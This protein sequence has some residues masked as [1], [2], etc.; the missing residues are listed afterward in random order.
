MVFYGD[1]PTATGC[2][3][4]YVTKQHLAIRAI[5]HYK[6]WKVI[7]NWKLRDHAGNERFYSQK[8]IWRWPLSA[9]DKA[10]GLNNPRSRRKY[11]E[12]IVTS[13][14]RS[15]A[16]LLSK[17]MTPGWTASVRPSWQ[18][19]KCYKSRAMSIG[20]STDERKLP[21]SKFIAKEKLPFRYSRYW[22]SVHEK[23]GTWIEK[24]CTEEIY[25]QAP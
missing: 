9:G 17:D 15:S 25:G 13:R 5:G 21:H 10:H 3:M 7:L 24:K 11:G 12:A 1:Q 20:I 18:I 4:K 14:G 19:P 22:K 8:I 2:L 23:Y 16:L 6:S